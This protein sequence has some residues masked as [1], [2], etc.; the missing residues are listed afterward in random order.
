MAGFE[1][2][3]QRLPAGFVVANVRVTA[4]HPPAFDPVTV[5]A[6]YLEDRLPGQAPTTDVDEEGG[7]VLTGPAALGSQVP[8]PVGE[9]VLQ[10]VER[11]ATDRH[12]PFLA[13]LAEHSHV[14][15]GE[16]HVGYAPTP[17][18]EILPP[19]VSAFEAA[20]PNV[21]LVLHDLGSTE[22][23]AGLHEGSLDLGIMLRPTEETAV[24]LEFKLLK[25]YPLHAMIPAR[26]PFTKLKRVP[27]ARLADAPLVSLRRK[28]Y[29]DYNRLLLQLFDRIK[30]QPRIV[31]ECDS[32][33]SVMAE[34]QAGR[35]IAIQPA[36]YRHVIGAR[37]KLRPL[38]P[39][40]LPH[41]ELVVS[42]AKKGDQ[43]VRGFAR[44]QRIGVQRDDIFDFRKYIQVAR[45]HTERRFRTA[46]Q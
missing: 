30:R 9:V 19:A 31:T 8:A 42:R 12:A 11:G 26:H 25:R 15:F 21:K 35:G 43:T 44:H 40:N 1:A 18:V 2:G 36:V 10:G 24:G 5:A 41:M 39:S 16:L 29:S 7:R 14:P 28:E 34:V 17:A 33:S 45:L 27:L 46:A 37:L 20:A 32:G 23:A 13:S 38:S 6:H 4:I 3:G 22:I